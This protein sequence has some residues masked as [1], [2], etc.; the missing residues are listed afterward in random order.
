MFLLIVLLPRQWNQDYL[1]T[2][3]HFRQLV[4]FVNDVCVRS[5]F[6]ERSKYRFTFFSKS[7]SS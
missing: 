5:L 7:V 2:T 1:N 6:T 4:L 3:S